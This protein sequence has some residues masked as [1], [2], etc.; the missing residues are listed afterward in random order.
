LLNVCKNILI[1]TQISDNRIELI[2][3]LIKHW[4]LFF[5]L[6]TLETSVI[7]DCIRRIN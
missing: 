6:G 1:E 2:G 7:S 3:V 4:L 5:T